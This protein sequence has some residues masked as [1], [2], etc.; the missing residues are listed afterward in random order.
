[1][2]AQMN[3]KDIVAA[4]RAVAGQGHISV[5]V[6]VIYPWHCEDVVGYDQLNLFQDAV[7]KACGTEH[8]LCVSSGTAAL[9]LAMLVAG[10]EPNTEVL[11]PGLT[12][13]ATANAATYCGAI[14]HFVDVRATDFGINPFKL[15]Q[16]LKHIAEKRGSAVFNKQTGRRI[17]ALVA[18][19]LLGVPCE[20]E[21]IKFE[22]GCWRLN[23]IEDAA[24]ALGSRYKGKPCGSNAFVGVLSFNNNKIVT[25]NGGGALLTDDPWIQAKAWELGTTAR[26]GHPWRM[27]DHSSIAYNYRMGNINAALGIPQL[28]R[29]E[30]LVAL[31]HKVWA[32]Y[33]DHGL[34]IWNFADHESRWNCWH[35][36]L[37]LAPLDNRRDEICEALTADGISCRTLFT[38]LHMLPFY[39]DN[40]R[41]NLDGA[42]EIWRSVICL[43]SSPA[44]G[45]RL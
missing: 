22:A 31:K 6:P 44:L 42:V 13:V 21:R 19:D 18:V 28:E 35:I 5:H 45:E 30:K 11:M 10:V 9:H 29:L 43:P 26:I 3:T 40:P 37:M 36:S 16:H 15:S 41:D 1:M 2:L 39:K 14:P 4:V 12:F 32:A 25:T 27:G 7:A 24:E 23:V 20:I 33:V 38:P 17:S 8:S 34:P